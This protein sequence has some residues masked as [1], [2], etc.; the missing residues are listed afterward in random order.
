MNTIRQSLRFIY[1]LSFVEKILYGFLLVIV[2]HF[3]QFVFDWGFKAFGEFTN[4]VLRHV[5]T[6]F[7]I[8]VSALL[9][10]TGCFLYFNKW[11]TL[12][13]QD[14]DLEEDEEDFEDISLLEENEDT[15]ALSLYVGGNYN[16][17]I[18][19]DYV[20]IHGHQININNDF[21]QVADEIRDLVD[22]LKTQGYKQED[23]ED[24]IVKELEEKSLKNPRIQ[25]TLRRLRKTFNKNNNPISYRELVKEVV[26][27]ATSYSQTNSKDFTDVIGGDFH[28][29][30]ELLQLKR[31]KEADRETAKII[32][33][34]SQ[35]NLPTSHQYRRYSPNYIVEEHIT[36]IPKKY[37]KTIDRLWIKH[38]NGRFGFGVQKDILKKIMQDEKYANSYHYGYSSPIVEK[39]GDLVGWRKDGDWLYY[40][41]LYDSLKTSA[42]GHLPLA[43]M[44]RSEELDKCRIDIDI[45]LQMID[46]RTIF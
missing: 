28:T 30:N 35:Q 40:V 39:F 43:Y 15:E 5:Y 19:G 11:K 6:I 20:E 36:A 21:A 9:F 3:A 44:L 22:Y 38:S 37:L 13:G 16:E 31:W 23:A 25:K 4:W 26:K 12:Q 17:N 46:R 8:I 32:Y 14:D 42:K 45:L 41:D 24:E 29:L 1:R 10:G 27:T 18:H 33:A 7:F 34:I 2:L